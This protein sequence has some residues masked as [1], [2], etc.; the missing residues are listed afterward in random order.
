MGLPGDFTPPSKFVRATYG[1]QNI[2]GVDNEEEGV[3][4][5]FRILSNCEVPKGGVI[6]EEVI[7]DTTIY[8]SAICMESGICTGLILFNVALIHL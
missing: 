3:S 8:T 2:Q 7:L 4:A 6:T 1:K 5:V